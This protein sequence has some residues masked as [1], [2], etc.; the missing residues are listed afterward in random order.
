VGPFARAA[1][2][3]LYRQMLEVMRDYLL[4]ATAREMRAT[5]TRTWEAS[6]NQG[7][8][9][10]NFLMDEL[11][12]P[13]LFWAVQ[14]I[15]NAQ[16]GSPPDE[17]LPAYFLWIPAIVWAVTVGLVIWA[18]I[19]KRKWI[20]SKLAGSKPLRM[21]FMVVS[22]GVV[23]LIAGI[24]VEGTDFSEIA[25]LRVTLAS[26]ICGIFVG[27]VAVL[28][29]A[30]QYL[31]WFHDDNWDIRVSKAE[32][33][34]DEARADRDF[35]MLLN[36][37]MLLCVE[38]QKDRLQKCLAARQAQ[39]IQLPLSAV[40]Q[41]F[42]PNVQLAEFVNTLY[43]LFAAEAIRRFPGE[44]VRIRAGLFRVDTSQLKCLHAWN[45]TRRD[46]LASPVSKSDR[47]SL[48][49]PKECLAVFSAVNS[50]LMIIEDAEVAN[51]SGDSP[52]NYF[53]TNQRSN[54]Q[55][56]LVLPIPSIAANTTTQYVICIDCNLKKMF[57]LA[58]RSHYEKI[59]ANLAPRLHELELIEEV[60]KAASSAA[61]G[62]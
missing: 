30:G 13:S 55:S 17:L 37:A 41:A 33:E 12:S 53:D 14:G 45:G 19:W 38:R 18:V 28:F 21:T 11:L 39:T 3:I 56:I 50:T 26:L 6:C 1:S 59:A 40:L 36:R 49:Q 47:F 9:G 2:H 15:P 27:P 7:R 34:R 29:L 10:Y 16:E 44:E 62:A 22:I 8:Q 5:R 51:A 43:E 61:L 48:S 58:K 20:D 52:F 23:P 32:A 24:L 57:D 25:N 31:L 42:A 35:F 46:C 4:P 54:I 60:L